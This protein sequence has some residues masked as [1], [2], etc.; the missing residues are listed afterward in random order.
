MSTTAVIGLS[1][2]VYGAILST[3]N[4]IIQ[5]IAHR[6]DRADVVLKI[7]RNMKTV[8]RNRRDSAY[9]FIIVTA[10]NRGKRPV[11]I[12]GFSVKLL[13]SWDEY[14]LG[15]IRPALPQE[16]T[17]SQSVSAF[18]DQEKTDQSLIE[19]YYV[20]DSVGRNFRLNMVPWWRVVLSR[21]RRKFAPVKRI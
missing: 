20:W 21:A 14:L 2:A 10:T 11:R 3:I 8:G 13:D 19:C 6:R 9:T 5:V 1:L 12:D 4:S 18:I 17:E 7:R 16:I 15:D